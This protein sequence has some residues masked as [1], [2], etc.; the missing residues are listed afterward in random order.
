MTVYNIWQLRFLFASFIIPISFTI[1]ILAKEDIKILH[2]TKDKQINSI[3][4]WAQKN[5]DMLL[6]KYGI[7]AESLKDSRMLHSLYK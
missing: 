6:Q 1:Q 5:E 4:A 3:M 7:E 2:A